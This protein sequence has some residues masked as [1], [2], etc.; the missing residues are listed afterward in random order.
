MVPG[1]TG[2]YFSFSSSPP[3]SSF[4]MEVQGATHCHTEQLPCQTCRQLKAGLSFP[5][6]GHAT[7]SH[8]CFSSHHK[9]CY[10]AGCLLFF[11]SSS[12]SSTSKAA[13]QAFLSVAKASLASQCFLPCL[14]S[15]SALPSFPLF[16][17]S[18]SHTAVL[19]FPGSLGFVPAHSCSHASFPAMF[20]LSFLLIL[21]SKISYKCWPQLSSHSFL[22]FRLSAGSQQGKPSQ[23][24]AFSLFTLPLASVADRGQGKSGQSNM[25]PASKGDKFSFLQPLIE[26][27]F[28]FRGAACQAPPQ[29]AHAQA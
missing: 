16:L 18:V 28:S 5:S 8:A 1:S 13:A 20:S 7:P 27:L 3:T 26:G 21:R 11:S 25:P 9:C 22:S 4:F 19:P 29:H 12:V 10:K 17:P 23:P 15:L 2:T 24:G 6:S 14:P